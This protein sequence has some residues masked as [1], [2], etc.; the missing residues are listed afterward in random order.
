MVLYGMASYFHEIRQTAL[1]PLVSLHRMICLFHYLFLIKV[2]DAPDFI[3]E[4]FHHE[5]KGKISSSTSEL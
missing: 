2:W 5:Q 4:D 1:D 3:L